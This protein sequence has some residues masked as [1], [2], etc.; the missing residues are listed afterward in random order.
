MTTPISLAV[1]L[2]Q[3]LRAQR[4]AIG[5]SQDDFADRI[6]M[7]RAYYSAIERGEKNITLT[8]LQRVAQG[9]GVNMSSLL[10]NLD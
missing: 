8:T 2:G 6:H 3:S 5:L 10:K 7:H 9:F 4:R 1:K